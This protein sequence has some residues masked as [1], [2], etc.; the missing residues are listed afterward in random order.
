MTDSPR[1]G[2]IAALPDITGAGLRYLI[3]PSGLQDVGGR[4]AM[5]GHGDATVAFDVD[6]DGVR[7]EADRTPEIEPETRLWVAV[8]RQTF[9]DAMWADPTPGALV[10]AEQR[11]LLGHGGSTRYESILERAKS[12]DWLLHCHADF[13][14][15]CEMAGFEPTYVRRKAREL[16]GA[17]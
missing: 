16:L 5:N 1:T 17:R 2:A 10:T 4:V 9:A 14:Y 13:I 12:R 6:L 7:M 15:V 11:R 8:L 3:E